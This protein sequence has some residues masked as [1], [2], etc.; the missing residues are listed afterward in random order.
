MRMLP[1]PL[2][3]VMAIFVPQALAAP[4]VE[5][6]DAGQLLPSAQL[7]PNNTTQISGTLA[8]RNDVDLYGFN[9][10]GGNLTIQVTATVFDS[11][12]FLF[13]SVGQ[14]VG[15]ADNPSL[16]TGNL[17]A[18]IYFLGISTFNVDPLNAAS[19]DIEDPIGGG[20]SSAYQP[21]VAASVLGDG[22][23][24]SWRPS[25]GGFGNYTITFSSPV[26]AIS[27][28][29]EPASLALWSIL[30]TAGIA[31]WRRKRKASAAA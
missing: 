3:V 25:N 29:P 20:T 23:L 7:V 31:A 9:W 11:Q 27:E 24:A 17:T 4:I 22:V 18:G 10:A 2:I 30:G 15:G 12:I 21:G 28:V 13:D 6:G 14:I 19:Q 5:V 1:L 26:N 16:L 8:S